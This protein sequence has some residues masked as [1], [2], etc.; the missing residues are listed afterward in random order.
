[1]NTKWIN[2]F[3]AILL[4]L[5][6]GLF[7]AQNLGYIDEFS[8]QVWMYVLAGASALFLVTYL[9]MGSGIGAGW[10]LPASLA[11]RPG[12]SGWPRRAST[13]RSSL[14]RSSGASP[15]PSS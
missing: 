8:D 6:G 1:M 3:W 10:S 14:R 11:A 4:I 9:V 12:R 7:L 13:A 2:L 15:C 5:G